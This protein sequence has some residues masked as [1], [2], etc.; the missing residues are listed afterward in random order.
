MV[1]E[2]FSAVRSFRLVPKMGHCKTQERAELKLV[3]V[4]AS[5]TPGRMAEVLPAIEAR[6]RRRR[7][8][9]ASCRGDR[10]F[11]VDAFD[12]AEDQRLVAGP[13]PLE[14]QSLGIAVIVAPGIG[15]RLAAARTV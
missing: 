5:A 3:Q 13:H 12:L 11:A 9:R 8:R 4:F 10:R 1:W 2:L 6:L 15:R 7:C 14:G